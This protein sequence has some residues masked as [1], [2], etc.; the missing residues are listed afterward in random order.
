VQRPLLAFVAMEDGLSADFLDV[1]R[2]PATNTLHRDVLVCFSE[3]VAKNNS[4]FIAGL[5]ANGFYVLVRGASTR[6]S[7]AEIVENH[8]TQLK[9]RAR[10]PQVTPRPHLV[11]VFEDDL[12]TIADATAAGACSI[13][14]GDNAIEVEQLKL[15]GARLAARNVDEVLQTFK[16]KCYF[17][18]QY[19][20]YAIAFEEMLRHKAGFPTS[21]FD[22]LHGRF[23]ETGV[24]VNEHAPRLV[25]KEVLGITPGTL[26]DLYMNNV[27]WTLDSMKTWRINSRDFER[28]IVNMFGRYYGIKEDEMS[29]FVTSGGT[30]GNF[31]GLW[32]QRDYLRKLAYK[33]HG[34]AGVS[35][36][37]GGS[38]FWPVL[39]MSSHTHYSSHKAAQQLGLPLRLVAG[40]SEGVLDIVEFEKAIKNIR[41]TMPERPI[42]VHVTAGTTQTGAFDDLVAV[43][44][45][46]QRVVGDAVPHSTHLDAAL[47]GAVLPIVRPWGDRNVFQDL[48]VKTL[49]ISGH[50]FFGSTVICG[51]CLTTQSFLDECFGDNATIVGYIGDLH[52]I[53]PSGSRSGFSVLSFHN[54]L[55]TLDMHTDRSRLKRVVQQCYRN[56]EMFIDA[57]KAIVGPSNVIC[58]PHS[59]NVCFPRPDDRIMSKYHLMPISLP[60]SP[61]AGPLA[62]SCVLLNMNEELISEFARDYK[63][64]YQVAP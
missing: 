3:N 23:T 43:R 9:Q 54:T 19:L 57:M 48:G 25:S 47:M 33:A 4:H 39:V 17:Q 32:W 31:C 62:G 51:I 6:L 26:A 53:T 58:P 45:I 20:P 59:L 21:L 29:G 15:H 18:V 49:A 2:R 8:Y 7:Y 64:Q 38:E 41:L 12:V 55:C 11:I 34:A 14:I 63:Q 46:L 13:G 60:Q 50:K 5:R 24:Q 52:D 16:V 36:T 27:G 42:L 30:E 40:T 1:L 44:D 28:D 35:I 10:R 22:A 56:R 61:V 37:D